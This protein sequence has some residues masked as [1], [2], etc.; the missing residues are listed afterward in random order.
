MT[1]PEYF[2]SGTQISPT[3]VALVLNAGGIGDYIHYTKAI[4]YAI[5]TTPYIHGYIGTP[6]YFADL[7]RLW[8]GHF[9]DRFRIKVTDDFSKEKFLQG[10]PCLVPDRKQFA[11][12][13]GFHPT[14]L[15]FIYYTQRNE[16]P[17][18]WGVLPPIRGDERDLTRFALPERY[19]VIT[20][21]ATDDTRRLEAGAI[22]EICDHLLSVGTTPVFLGKY[23]V[24]A[25]HLG[26]PPENLDTTGVLDLREQT[27]LVEAACIMARAQFVLGLDNGLLHLASCSD[28]PIIWIFTTVRPA[29]R[30]GERPAGSRNIIITPPKEL[31]CRFCNSNMRYIMGHD[32]KNCLYKDNA[33]TKLIRGSDLIRIIKESAL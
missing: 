25:T 8:L 26:V 20:P 33:C 11:N 2:R 21:N 30:I 12:A 7:A 3:K 9:R 10:V 17:E 13:T 19:A 28:V 15:G 23:A 27:D 5:E 18:G 4:Q 24:T 6:T 31:A 1:L 22:R 32:F 16:V 29:L 14:H